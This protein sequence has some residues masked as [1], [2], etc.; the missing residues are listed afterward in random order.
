MVWNKANRY[1]EWVDNEK[2]GPWTNWDPGEP[3][4]MEGTES[5]PL[6]CPASYDQNC[7][8]IAYK[9]NKWVWKTHGCYNEYP[10]LCHSCKFYSYLT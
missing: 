5:E 2:I 9:S 7:V 8:R 6:N 3:N 1:F 10:I 4:C